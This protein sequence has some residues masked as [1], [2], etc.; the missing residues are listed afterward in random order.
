MQTKRALVAFSERSADIFHQEL[1]EQFFSKP[2]AVTGNQ[3]QTLRFLPSARLVTPLD[4]QK[5]LAAVKLV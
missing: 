4:P 1:R 2:P 3:P 5:E